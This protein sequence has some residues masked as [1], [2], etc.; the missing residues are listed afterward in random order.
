MT[1]DMLL[2]GGAGRAVAPGRSRAGSLSSPGHA[3]APRLGVSGLYTD[4]LDRRKYSTPASLSPPVSGGW[5][6][7]NTDINLS[8]TLILTGT[9][10][11]LHPYIPYL[12]F[13]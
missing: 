11:C 4:H 7:N 13:H 5:H 9:R 10:W 12:Y 2:R 3:P 1:A 6:Q 8:F